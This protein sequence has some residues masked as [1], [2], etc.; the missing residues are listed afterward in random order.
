MGLIDQ[1]G[2]RTVFFPGLKIGEVAVHTR[3]ES[4]TSPGVGPTHPVQSGASHRSRDARR[5]TAGASL[6]AGAG[7]GQ[8]M[9][10]A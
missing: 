6:P 1:E 9:M 5:S 2:G 4:V 8:P 10:L 3:D 7:E